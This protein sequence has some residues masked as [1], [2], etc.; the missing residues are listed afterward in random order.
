MAASLAGGMQVAPC[1]VLNTT[2]LSG[3]RRGRTRSAGSR[4]MRAAYL[5]L[6]GHT[7]SL[8]LLIGADAPL[9]GR[10]GLCGREPQR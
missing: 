1:I 6:R 10:G 3:N 9:F 5:E 7:Q 2:A 8:R 4:D